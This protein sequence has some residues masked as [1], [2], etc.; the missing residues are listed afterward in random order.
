MHDS[1]IAGPLYFLMCSLIGSNIYATL[2]LRLASALDAQSRIADFVSLPLAKEQWKKEVQLLFN[3][4]LARIMINARDIARGA[5]GEYYGFE[6]AP[7]AE[8]DICDGTYLMKANGW[9]NVNFT[10][11]MWIL[12]T[13][14]LIIVLAIPSNNSADAEVL[15]VEY[16]CTWVGETAVNTWGHI[17]AMWES[18]PPLPPWRDFIPTMPPSLNFLRYRNA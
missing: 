13:S 4:S 10:G 16:V 2:Y 9:R 11:F 3:I 17:T 6:K 5:K 15:F 1:K 14:L 18:I 7:L 8:V 12:C